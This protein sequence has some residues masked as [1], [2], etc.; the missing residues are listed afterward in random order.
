MEVVPKDKELFVQVISDEVEGILAETKKLMS[1]GENIIVKI[2][3]SPNGLNSTFNY[4]INKPQYLS[5]LVCIPFLM[6]FYTY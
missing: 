4:T 2:P 5:L 1:F 3:A 6:L